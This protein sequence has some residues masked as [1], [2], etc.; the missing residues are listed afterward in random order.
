MFQNK[1]L[2][3]NLQAEDLF[4]SLCISQSILEAST[5]PIAKIADCSWG[6]S[7]GVEK[8]NAPPSAATLKA[9]NTIN[10]N[11]NGSKIAH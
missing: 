9:N 1:R 5:S 8:K 6:R 4:P 3:H 7:S 10:N 11:R 2:D